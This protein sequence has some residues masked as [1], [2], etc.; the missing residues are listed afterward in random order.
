MKNPRNDN[1]CQYAKEAIELMIA[2][3]V[4]VEDHPAKQALAACENRRSP[5]LTRRSGLTPR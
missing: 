4:P 3:N 2:A 5:P 1:N